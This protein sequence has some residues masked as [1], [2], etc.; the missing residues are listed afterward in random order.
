MIPRYA[1]AG[2]G[3]LLAGAT[4]ALATV[5]RAAKPLHPD[6]E[7]VTGRLHRRGAGAGTPW[8][9]VPWLD[10]PGED[11]VDVR[12]SRAVGLPGWLPDIHG[13]AVRVH[14]ADGAGDLL[15][16]TTGRGRVS[17]FVLTGCRQPGQ[18][19]MTTL[20]PYETD[21]GAVLLGAEAAGDS[22]Y[23]LSWA[24]PSGDWHAFADLRLGAVPGVDVAMSFDPIR[25]QLPGL[26]QYPTVVRLRE[27]AYLR[28][29]RSRGQ[30]QYPT[31]EENHHVQ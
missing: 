17:R 13:L 3:A 4:S 26:R 1:S 23:E 30:D 25:R 8:T 27:P 19:P 29:R 14:T 10:E 11:D 15:F 18:R 20:L 31:T 2:G 16:A 21:T 24:R 12:R 5:R 28:A 9:G 7:V 22:T 6:G